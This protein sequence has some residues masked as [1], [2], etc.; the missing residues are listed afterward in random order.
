MKI[1][2]KK[3]EG[4]NVE[5]VVIPRPEEDI[6]FFCEAIENYDEFDE[7]CPQPVAPEVLY[8]G[9]LR[10]KNPES[11]EY[12]K[13][14]NEWGTQRTH[15]TIL[16]SISNTPDIEWETV[17]LEKPSTWKNYQTE[18]KESHFTDIEMYRIIQGV[19]R[20]NSLD[21]EM[22]KEAKKNFLQGQAQNA[23]K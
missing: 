13:E 7:L 2:G 11:P 14:L 9:G 3:P 17:D 23:G 6:V 16:K 12:L 8:P 22:L 10:K 1:R 20:A 19:M 4:R 5:V 18:L 15:W 21:E